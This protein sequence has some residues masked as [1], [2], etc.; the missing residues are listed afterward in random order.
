MFT[1]LKPLFSKIS[2]IE[3]TNGCQRAVDEEVDRLDGDSLLKTSVNDLCD[4]FEKKY[5]LEPPSLL[6]EAGYKCA[7][8]GE[9][10]SPGAGPRRF[11]ASPPGPP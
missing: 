11:A 5:R 3:H 10:R 7:S 6:H 2:I 4:Y 1:E 8:F 9:S